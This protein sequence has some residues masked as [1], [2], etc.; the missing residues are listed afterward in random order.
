MSLKNCNAKSGFYQSESQLA[1]AQVNKDNLKLFSKTYCQG[2][3]SIKTKRDKGTKFTKGETMAMYNLRR[4]NLCRTELVYLQ[5]AQK[6][7]AQ[8]VQNQIAPS[9]VSAA[10]NFKSP[11]TCVE[12]KLRRN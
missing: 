1:I 6:I 12:Y 5:F 10:S 3:R 7:F 11:K 9:I 2:K 4:R 8:I